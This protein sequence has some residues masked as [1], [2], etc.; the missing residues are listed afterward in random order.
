MTR[1]FTALAA[2]LVL[3]GCAGLDRSGPSSLEEV[4]RST[5]TDGGP[6]E[7][8]LYTVLSERFDSGAHTALLI[9]GSQ[10]VLWDPAGS[11][12]HPDVP[13]RGD[14]LYGIDENIRRVYVDYHVRPTHYMV[15]QT[16][17]VT[18]AQADAIMALAAEHGSASR[19]TCARSTS[20]ILAEAGVDI[21]R[22]WFPEGLRRQFGRLPGVTER[23]ITTE[24]VDTRHNVIFG[25]EGVPLPP[26]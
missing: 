6:P 20:A 2:L 8:R 12:V 21:G 7:I 15:E 5:F 4:Q 3:A 19:S 18:R 9:N 25:R 22:T 24:N 26:A 1:L 13:E 14:L 23:V 10:R 16:L 17:P 11:F